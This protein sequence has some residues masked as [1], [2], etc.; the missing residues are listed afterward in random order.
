MNPDIPPEDIQRVCQE[1]QAKLNEIGP[2]K[3]STR[4]GQEQL[5]S[6]I[7]WMV[8]ASL[9]TALREPVPGTGVRCPS[10]GKD[11]ENLRWTCCNLGLDAAYMKA[12]NNY[13]ESL[14]K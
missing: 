8:H 5:Q 4:E 10:C 12:K 1:F 11:A 6:I 13:A 3:I 14:K 9:L 7:N 2:E